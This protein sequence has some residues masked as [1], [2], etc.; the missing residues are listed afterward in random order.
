MPRSSVVPPGARLPSK[1]GSPY[2]AP[3]ARQFTSVHATD[4]STV[5]TTE[6]LKPPGAVP[7][8]STFRR[9]ESTA[10]LTAPTVLDVKDDLVA[11]GDFR[12]GIDS[13]G[14][15]LDRLVAGR[16]LADVLFRAKDFQPGRLGLAG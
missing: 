11:V 7:V 16:K 14:R 9:T 12:L 10:P 13:V 8:T 5:N 4:G 1:V 15:F 2:K 6:E 3:G